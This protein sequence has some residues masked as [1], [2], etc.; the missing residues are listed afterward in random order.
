MNDYS[1]RTVVVDSPSALSY[2][3]GNVVYKAEEVKIT[4]LSQ[5]RS[6]IINNNTSEIS[7]KL[8]N[9]LC[10]NNVNVI[11]CDEKHEP[12]GELMSVYSHSECAGKIIEQSNWTDR[13]KQAVWKQ[14]VEQ[15][16]G[17]QINLLKIFEI[18]SS[19]ILTE[20]KNNVLP[21]DRSNREG[22]A[23]RV[24]FNSLFGKSFSRRNDCG[25]NSALNYG[26][27]LIQSAFSRAVAA[28][29]YHTALGIKHCSIKNRYNL[30]CDL[31]EPFRPFI[32]K[33]VYENK[34]RPLDYEYKRELI[35]FLQSDVRYGT[36][37]MNICDAADR[38]TCDV[39]KAMKEPE[40]KIREVGFY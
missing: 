21:F 23:A 24:Y 38:Y 12:F 19:D 3:N 8:I 25:I 22:L 29:G 9:E 28:H 4:P 37:R 34:N 1:W 5:I 33:K 6:I 40:H 36:K 14:I 26:Y 16:I 20:C 15:K 39:L 31:M 18:P 27:A 30:S 32:D 7:V 13:S 11:I 17:N 2:E 35:E 10:R